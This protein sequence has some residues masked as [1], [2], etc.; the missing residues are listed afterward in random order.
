MP[1]VMHIDLGLACRLNTG[2]TSMPASPTAVRSERPARTN[3]DLAASGHLSAE[4]NMDIRGISN[5]SLPKCIN[6]IHPMCVC[7]FGRF[8][9]VSN[10]NYSEG[11]SMQ[12]RVYITLVYVQSLEEEVTW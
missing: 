6:S 8:Q 1:Q 5:R 3:S 4:C 11:S 7:V 12:E 2:A 10:N 9:G